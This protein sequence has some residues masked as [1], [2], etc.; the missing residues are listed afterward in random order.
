MGEYKNIKDS[1]LDHP[2][3]RIFTIDRFLDLIKT[4]ENVL[5]NPRLWDDP[6]ENILRN[7]EYVKES[8]EFKKSYNLPVD[9]CVYGQCWSLIYDND[10]LW[11]TYA[12]NR[13]GVMIQSTYRKLFNSLYNSQQFKKIKQEYVEPI[14]V[15]EETEFQREIDFTV[16][17]INYLSKKQIIDKLKSSNINY[18]DT[19]L[20]KRKEFQDEREVRILLNNLPDY[21]DQILILQDD[22]FKYDIEI[23]ELIDRVIFD[24]RMS[25]IH[26]KAIYDYIRNLGYENNITKL[27]TYDLPDEEIINK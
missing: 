26:Y 5:V 1:E 19:L 9:K 27:D 3:Y 23:N 6:Y 2:I 21:M 11:R 12:P 22:I 16:G 10:L 4:S 24:A 7:I 13:N 15:D 17:K 14:I 18:F 20:F 25:K 8:D